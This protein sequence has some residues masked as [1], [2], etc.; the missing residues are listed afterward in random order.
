MERRTAKRIAFGIASAGLAAGVLLY[1]L[2]APAPANAY[3]FSNKRYMYELE[4]LGGKSNVMTARLIDDFAG[5]WHGQNLA[6]TV[7]TLSVCIAW[8]FWFFATHP[9]DPFPTRAAAPN[10]GKAER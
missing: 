6:F 2:A 8:L 10:D 9:L 1:V 5:L 3:G 7:A 4:R